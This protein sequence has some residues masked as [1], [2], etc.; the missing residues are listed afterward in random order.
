MPYGDKSPQAIQSYTV[1]TC[2]W[3]LEQGCKAILIAC[4]SAS[5]T[6]YLLAKEYVGKRAEVIDVIAP[7]V[8]YAN[9]ELAGKSIG[10]IA[11]RATVMTNV[12][13]ELINAANPTIQV[14]AVATP[15][16]A[17]MIEEGFI[18]DN[19]S[20]SLVEAYLSTPSLQSIDA[21]ILGCT[22]YPLIKPMIEAF[23]QGCVTVVDSSDV[24]AKHLKKRL[25]TT[26]LLRDYDKKVVQ[27]S[28]F[29]VS[30]LTSSFQASAERFLGRKANLHQYQLWE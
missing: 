13:P 1:K 24:V 7:T 27:E 23:Y 3:F 12:Y 11:T 21:L 15:L 28:S 2:H 6:S 25:L 9:R 29:F 5:A 8:E 18:G 30:D 26:D 14:H 19:V 17:S 22:H 4:N 16:L 20:R 10:V